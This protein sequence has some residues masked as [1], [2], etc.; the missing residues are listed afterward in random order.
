MKNGDKY[1]FMSSRE[2]SSG[3]VEKAPF[4]K[5]L[6]L[7]VIWFPLTA[8]DVAASGIRLFVS[9]YFSIIE[10]TTQ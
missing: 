5:D 9:I 1:I 10:A 7:G 8:S 3:A 6:S 4:I 2:S